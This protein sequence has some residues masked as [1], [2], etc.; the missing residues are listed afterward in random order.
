M[1]IKFQ[2]VVESDDSQPQIIQEITE[3]ERSYLQPENL[4]LS[5]TEAKTLLKKVQQTLV[6]QQIAEY[7]HQQN[8]CQ[9]CQKKLLHKDKR[10]IV[11]RTL[12]GKL[13]LPCNRLFHC[14]CQKHS[15]RTFQPLANLLKQ[16]TSPELLYLES[17]FASLMSYGLSVKLLEELLPIEGQ[18]NPTTVRN[19]VHKIA[20]RLENELGDEI[21]TY[22]EGTPRDWEQLPRPDLPLVVGVDGGYVRYYDKHNKKAGNFEVIVG[23]SI[24]ADSTS[25]RFGFTYS[26]DDKPKRRI[27]EVLKSQGMQPHQQV[28]VISD[29][30]EKIREL[31]WGLNPSTEHILDW[32]HITMRITV[33]NQMAK[34]LTTKDFK[35][36]KS[37][38]EDLTSVKWYLWHGN[39]YKA[40]QL[41]QY[42][43]DDTWFL[44]KGERKSCPVALKL[45]DMME[46]F[47]TYISNNEGLIPNY[48]ERWRYE[49][50]ISSS[51]VE[52]TVNQVISKRM[53]KKQQMRWTPQGAHLL[54]QIRTQVLNGE[55]KEKFQHWYSGIQLNR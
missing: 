37:I 49:E 53:V 32:F 50:S 19:N 33:M 10:T 28:T 7:E 36:R 46:K 22:I 11:Y 45:Y 23:K 6:E 55:L 1:K 18:I 47:H 16:R 25:K 12:F 52:S 3:I 27:F 39:V 24:K 4:G 48:G 40:L 2:V 54:L 15:T 43:L 38:K 41:I 42:L 51:F 13:K 8:S 44:A 30:D 31:L 9:H 35:L 5:L 21:D 34:G 20:Q 29:G 17:K 26:Y 14:S